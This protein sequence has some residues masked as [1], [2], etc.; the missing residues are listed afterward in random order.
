MTFDG[1]I[2][3]IPSGGQ[4]WAFDGMTKKTIT[5]GDSSKWVSDFY[6]ARDGYLYV[7]ANNVIYR[8]N[9]LANAFEKVGTT[10]GVTGASS[11]I[12]VY[13]DYIYIGGEYCLRRVVARLHP[14][15]R[16]CSMLW[17]QTQMGSR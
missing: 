7:L 1:H 12:A 3:C 17:S 5:F 15:L 6:V 9:S 13:G 14:K 4:L 16:R 10:S 11:A 2:V 8:T